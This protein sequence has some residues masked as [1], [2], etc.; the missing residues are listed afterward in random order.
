MTT[1]EDLLEELKNIG[2]IKDFT[3]RDNKEAKSGM[4]LVKDWLVTFGSAQP[5]NLTMESP[6]RNVN[7]QF[8]AMCDW[9]D[10]P[11]GGGWYPRR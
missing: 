2:V 6:E 3:H 4:V 10:S 1:A 7:P 5:A 11:Y 9:R 8:V